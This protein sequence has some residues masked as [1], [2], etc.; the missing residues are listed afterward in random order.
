MDVAVYEAK[1]RL[2]ELLVAVEQGQQVT[3]TRHGRAVAML[4]GVPAP[5]RAA[6]NRSRQVASVFARLQRN[7]KGVTLGDDL[8]AAIAEGR[9]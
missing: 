7:R 8:H 4:V 5:K 6:A 9:D 3:I 1:T 2:S